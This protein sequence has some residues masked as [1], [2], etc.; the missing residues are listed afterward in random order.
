M[1]IAGARKLTSQ[2]E[3]ELNQL[4]KQ[5]TQIMLKAERNIKGHNTNYPW[6]PELHDSVRSVSI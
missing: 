1:Q 3:R 2:E 5:I 4:D 6:S